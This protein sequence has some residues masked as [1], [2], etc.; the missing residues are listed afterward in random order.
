MCVVCCVLSVA[1]CVLGVVCCVLRVV[2]CVLYVVCCVLCVV[3]CVLC[4]AC[5]VV[6]VSG[7]REG[8]VVPRVGEV[9]VGRVLLGAL[10]VLAQFAKSTSPSISKVPCAQMVSSADIL[11]LLNIHI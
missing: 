10:C 1:C 2:C 7:R 5:C 6:C 3:C 8:C 4:V 9:F 11:A